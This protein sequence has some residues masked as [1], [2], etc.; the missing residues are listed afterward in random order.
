M[1]WEEAVWGEGRIWISLP[2]S[3]QRLGSP[4]RV[5]SQSGLEG[6]LLLPGETEWED[7]TVKQSA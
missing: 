3:S 5:F 2:P 1:Q 6:V 7:L 4:G